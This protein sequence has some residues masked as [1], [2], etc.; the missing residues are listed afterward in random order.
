MKLMPVRMT[1]K[2]NLLPENS[3][4]N[5]QTIIHF[6]VN[7]C[8]DDDYE[9]LSLKTCTEHAKMLTESIKLD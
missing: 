1:N 8:I 6:L 5:Q 4:N 9:K 2:V 3:R 7:S